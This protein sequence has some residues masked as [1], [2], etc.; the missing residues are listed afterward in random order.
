MNYQH[1]LKFAD[2]IRMAKELNQ[3]E[4]DVTPDKK[5]QYAVRKG[6]LNGIYDTTFRKSVDNAVVVDCQNLVAIAKQKAEAPGGALISK[7]EYPDFRLPYPDMWFE[8]KAG[9]SEVSKTPF[10]RVGV[11]GRCVE[12]SPNADQ[13]VVKHLRDDNKCCSLHYDFTLFLKFK[14]V[15]IGPT[16]SI[17]LSVTEQGE[18]HHGAIIN[19]SDKRCYGEKVLRVEN[20]KH[21][22]NLLYSPD[23]AKGMTNAICSLALPAFVAVQLMNCKNII[24]EEKEPPTTI[25]ERHRRDHPP[26]VKYKI[27]KIERKG[28]A[29]QA[30]SAD[31]QNP[32]IMP[33]H[34][35]RG[36]F[37]RFTAEKPL[38]GRHVGTYWWEAQARGSKK[39]GEVIKDYE[40][41]TPK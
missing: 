12:K 26:L 24:Q 25:N 28:T 16:F 27:L 32:G 11:L 36:H 2:E 4:F 41:A 5:P 8:Y 18:I 13:H 35:C 20:G 7:E 17:C 23:V 22:V 38:L 40:V 3:R 1:V 14:G 29:A 33:Y 10:D 9:V 34:F 15:V 30:A 19:Y 6:T 21:L 31:I 39:Q 37:K